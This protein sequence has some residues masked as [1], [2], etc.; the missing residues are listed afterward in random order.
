METGSSVTERKNQWKRVWMIPVFSLIAAAIVVGL[1]AGV[2]Q[3]EYSSET[4]LLVVQKYT[5][6]DSYTASKSA[7]KISNNLAEA[8]HTT[9]FFDDVVV[10]GAVDVSELLLMPEK[11]KREEWAK[12]VETEV[13]SRTSM[14]R[15]RAYDA[16]PEQAEALVQAVTEVLLQNSGQYH[17][18]ADTVELRLVDAALTSEHPTR[19]SLLLNGVAAALF[20]AIVGFV[21]FL[22]QPSVSFPFK[23]V[24]G[25]GSVTAST[26]KPKPG[27]P[28]MPLKP[29]MEERIPYSVLEV[30]NFHKEIPK[31]RSGQERG[32]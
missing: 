29:L 20:G 3:R 27:T 23:G 16:N 12:M 4:R 32:K 18:A 15:I 1:L 5:L 26:P 6:T 14:L 21:V 28:V 22:L 24:Q 31:H 17:G 19:P 25:I 2:V 7:E 11:D 13:I 9:T 30:N 10:S 8:I